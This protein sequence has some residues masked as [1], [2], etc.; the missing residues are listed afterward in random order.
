MGSPKAL[1]EWRGRTFLEQSISIFEPYCAAMLV[2]LG[3]H[4]AAIRAGVSEN[5]RATFVENQEPD[6]GMLSS[7]QCGLSALPRGTDAFLFMPVD[8]PAVRPSTVGRLCSALEAAPATAF[9]AIARHDGRNGHPV[10]CRAELIAEFLALPATGMTSEVIHRH[11]QGTLYL[12]VDDAGVIADVDYP[13]DYRRL[14]EPS[15]AGSR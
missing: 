1:L 12:D 13:E 6:R 2:V 9:I 11:R 14:V 8:Q 15:A 3:H 5:C 10:A 4:A 7:L